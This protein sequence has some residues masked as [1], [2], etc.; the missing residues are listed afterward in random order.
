MKHFTIF[1]FLLFSLSVFSQEPQTIKVK[2]EQ[3]LVKA[4]FDNVE[5]RL[6]AID[7]FGNMAENKIKSY[8]LWIKGKDV[9]SF[10]GF[11]NSLTSEMIKELNKQKK[12]AKIYFTEINV[13]DDNGHLLKLPDVYEVW[14]PNCKNCDNKSSQR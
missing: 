6:T 2:K 11:D 8:K 12:A 3:N 10:N 5:L 4:Y 7:R 1:V 9:K 14:F 13:E